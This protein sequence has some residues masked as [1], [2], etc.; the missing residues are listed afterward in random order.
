VPEQES[1]K[2]HH[3]PTDGLSADETHKLLREH[4][5]TD[6]NVNQFQYGS[7]KRSPVR[8]LRCGCEN[9]TTVKIVR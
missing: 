3:V 4:Q 6:Q 9:D 8:R 7:R 1:D 5:S 2:S